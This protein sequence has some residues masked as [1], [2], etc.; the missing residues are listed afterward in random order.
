[1]SMEVSGQNATIYN[2]TIYKK[3]KVIDPVKF[4]KSILPTLDTISHYLEAK[5]DYGYFII[6]LLYGSKIL[7]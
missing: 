5:F 2:A 1:M 4:W 6:F 7:Q 3:P